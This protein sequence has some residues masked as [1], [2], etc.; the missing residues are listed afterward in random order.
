M[1]HIVQVQTTM[2]IQKIGIMIMLHIQVAEKLICGKRH[3]HK[4]Q[5]QTLLLGSIVIGKGETHVV[6]D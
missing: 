1:A 3:E 2:L 4:L 5:A 6:K